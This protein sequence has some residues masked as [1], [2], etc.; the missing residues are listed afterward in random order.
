MTALIESADAAEP[1][2]LPA[3][4]ALTDEVRALVLAAG[5]TAVDDAELAEVTAAVADLR[6]RLA[7]R[8]RPR[9]VRM[10][11]DAPARA[12]E[13]GERVRMGTFNPF[14]IPLVVR[15]D[16][17]GDGA[18][19]EL[20]ADARHEG[21]REHLH[22]G[23]S[24]WLMDCMLGILIQAHGRRRVTATLGVRYLRRTPLDVPLVLRARITRTD[25]RKVWAEGW[26]EAD[27]ERTVVAEGLFIEVETDA[28]R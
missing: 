21:P 15:F 13:T 4:A 20:T 6:A 27:G 14:G 19:A 9:L 25:G 3:L 16:E 24:S 28:R 5:T 2:D 12:R 22:G 17:D 10:P 1:A 8:S 11:F 23:I 18:T 7:A 26:I